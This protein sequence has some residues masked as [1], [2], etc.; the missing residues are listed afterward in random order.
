MLFEI[1]GPNLGRLSSRVL[2]QSLKVLL[3]G[4]RLEQVLLPISPKGKWPFET[5]LK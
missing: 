2:L 1:I 5:E 3:D 4:F